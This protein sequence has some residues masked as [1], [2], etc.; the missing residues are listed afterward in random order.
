[1]TSQT[2]PYIQSPASEGFYNLGLGQ[3]SPRLLPLDMLAKAASQRFSESGERLVLQ[4][5][6]CI[7]DRDSRATLAG[8]LSA[9]HGF[10]I[11]P[12][13]LMAAGSISLS[14]ALVCATF[15]PPG[16]LVVC[17]D[18]TYFLA[19]DIFASSGV[20]LIG[21]P[22]DGRGLDTEALAALLA[23]GEKPDL[24]YCIPGYHN[25]TSVVLSNQR[26]EQL[27]DLA[28]QHK[29][30]VVSD[31]PYNLLHY[32][33][34]APQPLA[35]LDRGRQRVVSLGSF[36]KI[37]GPGLRAGWIQAAPTLIERI[38][39]HGVLRSG[40]AL[41]PVIWQMIDAIIDDGSL[42]AHVAGLRTTFRNRSKVLSDALR[43]SVPELGFEEP[44]GGYFLW[45]TLPQGMSAQRLL[46]QCGSRQL[47]FAPGNRCAV[48][49]DLDHC[50]RL[51]FAFYEAQELATAAALLGEAVAAYT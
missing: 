26:R 22:V 30:T 43:D 39:A 19:R 9:E 13:T 3:P 7:G 50:I 10:D 15:V 44:G 8:F 35:S 49:A 31:E 2:G 16:G 38:A 40:G 20:R 45:A 1:M 28:E 14:L 46:D 23:A 24:V 42:A 48:S 32:Q 25:P 37:L 51:C 47:A 33:G 34:Q 29:F 17:E 36:S 6:T 4:Y 27:I 11:S 5:G 21:V 12:E 41:N 18:P